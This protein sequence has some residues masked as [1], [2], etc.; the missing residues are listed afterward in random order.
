MGET[1]DIQSWSQILPVLLLLR[2]GKK[3]DAAD[4][5]VALGTQGPARQY[6]N[7]RLKE[8]GMPRDQ[9]L[10]ALEELHRHAPE[11]VDVT[12]FLCATYIKAGRAVDVA[13]LLAN[14]EGKV[15]NNPYFWFDLGRTFHMGNNPRGA[16]YAYGQAI[17]IDAEW[18]EPLRFRADMHFQNIEYEKAKP[19]YFR[20]LSLDPSPSYFFRLAS[21]HYRSGLLEEAD[22]YLRLAESNAV[23]L[24]P[25]MRFTRACLDFKAGRLASGFR[26]FDARK[27]IV[28]EQGRFTVDEDIPVWNGQPLVGKRII[29]IDEQGY[30]DTLQFSRFLFRLQEMGAIVSFVTDLEMQSLLQESF[31]GIAIH[32]GTAQGVFDY[33]TLLLDIAQYCVATEADVGHC[34]GYLRASYESVTR[35]QS[36]LANKG[37]LKVGIAWQG[38]PK[39]GRDKV[40]SIP[41]DNTMP[42]LRRTDAQMVSLQYGLHVHDT[43]A[44]FQPTDQFE[45]FDVIAGLIANLDLVIS[46]D[47]SIAH[48][49]GAMGKRTWLLIDKGGDWRWQNNTDRSYWYDSVCIF[50]QTNLGDW[51]SIIQRVNEALDAFL[52]T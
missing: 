22:A 4:L 9:L 46:V 2:Q 37:K 12:A 18:A 38:N 27:E 29:V 31:P 13:P 43:P 52:S 3:K 14:L 6:A 51:H 50:Q 36:Q 17:A 33:Q 20:L 25:S 34:N 44:L 24:S 28:Q 19:D 41:L 49:A 35:W 1:S 39:N 40:R 42:L 11:A 15:S 7:L 45:N 16:A 8:G 47:T 30:G 26:N 5:L 10:A 48:L 32:V 21:L 23:Q